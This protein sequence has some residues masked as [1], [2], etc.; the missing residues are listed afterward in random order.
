MKKKKKCAWT[1]LV[2]EN[3]VFTEQLSCEFKK[4]ISFMQFDWLSR[5][6]L[7]VADLPAG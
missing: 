2:F 7:S 5:D 4:K 3:C 6:L 1:E